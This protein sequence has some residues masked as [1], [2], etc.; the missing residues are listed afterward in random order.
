MESL[1]T[2]LVELI[3]DYLPDISPFSRTSKELEWK[4]RNSIGKKFEYRS[5]VLE[6]ASFQ[7]LIFLSKSRFCS[8]LRH[9]ALNSPVRSTQMPV[10]NYIGI[11]HYRR[12][13]TEEVSGSLRE[14][15]SNFKNCVHISL[16]NRYSLDTT[17]RD[18]SCDIGL[19]NLLEILFD[20]IETQSILKGFD[21]GLAESDLDT[22]NPDAIV[23]RS[24][25]NVTTSL[26]VFPPLIKEHSGDIVKKTIAL[27]PYVNDLTLSI[28]NEGSF[29]V[30]TEGCIPPLKDLTISNTDCRQADLVRLLTN[31]KATLQTIRLSFVT[32]GVKE[33]WMPILGMISREMHLKLFD[34][35]S[36]MHLRNDDD[37]FQCTKECC[38]ELEEC[39]GVSICFT[40]ETGHN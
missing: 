8:S 18:L 24:L 34:V 20:A 30:I 15:L 19:Q 31:H 40:H 16:A 4:S 10:E 22:F 5:F 2:E 29:K 23:R 3:L 1:P 21:I 12:F 35:M 26:T 33:C 28:N 17:E 32:I 37:I 14:V 11:L 39:Y 6:P 25:F 36:C 38:K 9:L 7:D 13:I 27:F